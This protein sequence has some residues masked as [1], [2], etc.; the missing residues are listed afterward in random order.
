MQEEIRTRTNGRING[1]NEREK[2]SKVNIA[3]DS[4]ILTTLMNC[5]RLVD[6][7]FNQS[8]VSSSGKDNSLECGTLVHV[9]LEW[10]NKSR[11]NNKSYSDSVLVGFEAGRE[12]INGYNPDNKYILD[13]LEPGMRNTPEE[14][15]KKYTGWSYV[16]KTMEEYFEFWKN[17]SWT[18]IAA[19]ETRSDII[20]EDEDILILWKAKFDQIS[21]MPNGLMPV[22]HKSMKQRRDSISLNNQFIGQCRLLKTRNVMINKIGFQTS[23]KPEEKF[24][25]ALMSYS[26]DKI[27]EWCNEIVPFYARMYLAYHEAEYYPPNFTNC[28]GKYG[29]CD[30]LKI[31]EHDRN[32]RN[33][34]I[35]VEFITGKKWDV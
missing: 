6:F 17:D 24:T 31:C 27:A 19:E 4:Q 18:I 12:Y 13:E 29:Y 26:A 34:A 23:L 1:R 21:D 28:E 5:P 35:K 9:I 10:F 32:M 30:F 25:R 20:Y 16:L 33:E 14:S 2:M 15:D 11:I 7:R 3:L 22:D 8:L